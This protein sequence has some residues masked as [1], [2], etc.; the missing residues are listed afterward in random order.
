MKRIVIAAAALSA[1]AAP[2]FAQTSTDTTSFEVTATV[3]DVC[4]MGTAG[5]IALGAQSVNTTTGIDALL[6][7]ANDVGSSA[8]F[9]L[10]CN[11]S[12][13]LTMSSLNQGLETANAPS[14]DDAA[15]FTDTLHYRLRLI[16]FNDGGQGAQPLLATIDNTTRDFASGGPRH[17]QVNAQVTVLQADNALRPMAGSYTD[18]ATVTVTTL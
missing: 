3:P 9:W 4:T 1:F 6:L 13:T 12:F 17:R 7:N 11:D 14:G 16:D 15:L 5:N 2:A 8:A 18:T 10:S